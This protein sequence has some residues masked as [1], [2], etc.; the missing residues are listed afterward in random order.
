[1]KPERFGQ[2]VTFPAIAKFIESGIR[3]TPAP[4]VFGA[5]VFQYK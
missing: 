1:M 5:G 2:P 4:R 3:D